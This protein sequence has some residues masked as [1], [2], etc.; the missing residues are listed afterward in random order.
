MIGD[1]PILA[2]VRGRDLVEV[3]IHHDGSDSAVHV[4]AAVFDAKRLV[5]QPSRLLT[6]VCCIEQ[7]RTNFDSSE[8]FAQRD[9]EILLRT[10]EVLGAK[11]HNFGDAFKR[12]LQ[13]KLPVQLDNGRSKSHRFSPTLRTLFLCCTRFE[14]RKNYLLSYILG[15]ARKKAGPKGASRRCRGC[16]SAPLP[17]ESCRNKSALSGRN[18]VSCRFPLRG[19]RHLSHLFLL[20]GGGAGGQD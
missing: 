12:S 1:K 8:C 11:F 3:Q 18:G 5:E 13:L 15:A 16:P 6:C 14:I 10:P 17:H 9:H 19:R 20:P 4:D 2:L 7:D